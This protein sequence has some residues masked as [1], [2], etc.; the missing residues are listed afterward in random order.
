M[1][2]LDLQI[3]YLVKGLSRL[4]LSRGNC[5]K[6]KLVS[7]RF[8]NRD[9]TQMLCCTYQNR[10]CIMSNALLLTAINHN[11]IIEQKFLEVGHAQMEVDSFHS[12]GVYIYL[13]VSKKNPRPYNITYL[14][15]TFSK[16]LK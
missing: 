9:E 7:S 14:D 4:G 11:I 8:I 10:N 13:Q 3:K 12:C 15:H 6:V 16:P 5:S 1:T 2:R